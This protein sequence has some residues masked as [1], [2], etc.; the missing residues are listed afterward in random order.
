VAIVFIF[1]IFL[2]TFKETI[3]IFTDEEVKQEA[4]CRSSSSSRRTARR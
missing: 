3:P 2:F 4:N 1:L